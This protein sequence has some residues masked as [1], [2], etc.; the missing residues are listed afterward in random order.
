[1]YPVIEEKLGQEEK[2]LTDLD[3]EQHMAVS[4]F[5]LQ[6]PATTNGD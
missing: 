2:E 6:D 3:R 1:M 4:V 5:T